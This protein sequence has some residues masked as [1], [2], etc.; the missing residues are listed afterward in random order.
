MSDKTDMSF[1]IC[2]SKSSSG[3]SGSR[4]NSSMCMNIRCKK[5]ELT[6]DTSSFKA[7]VIDISPFYFTAL[8]LFKVDNLSIYM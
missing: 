4:A 5:Q 1:L 2:V 3:H 8:I 6:L 7:I